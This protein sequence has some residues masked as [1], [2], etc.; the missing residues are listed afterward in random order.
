MQA[1][2]C[3]L[4]FELKTRTINKLTPRDTHSG[5][6]D[7]SSMKSTDVAIIGRLILLELETLLPNDSPLA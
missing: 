7:G 4:E 2:P 6:F 5:E 1:D 3:V